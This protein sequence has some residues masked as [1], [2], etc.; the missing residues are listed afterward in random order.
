MSS[1]G[2][3]LDFESVARALLAHARTLLVE[4]F[5]A[6]RL[7][8]HEFLVGN[9]N[10]EPGESLSINVETGEWADFAEPDCRGGDLI[11]LYAAAHHIS[12]GEAA[13][14]LDGRDHT[15]T[16]V[17][18]Q[19]PKRT[20]ILP[21]PSTHDCV[22]FTYGRPSQTW[23]YRDANSNLLGYVARYDT[24]KGKQIAPWTYGHRPGQPPDWGM[25]SWPAPR[26]LYGLDDPHLKTSTLTI[27]VEGEKCVDSGRQIAPNCAVL[28][29]PGGAQAWNRADW[30]PLYGRKVIL[31]PDADKA[32]IQAMYA[33]GHELAKHCPPEFIKIIL[34]EPDKPQGWDAANALAEKWNFSTLEAWAKQ[35]GEWI[36]GAPPPAVTS[37]AQNPVSSNGNRPSA[38]RTIPDHFWI[39]WDLDRK[40][41]GYPR[42]NANNALTVIENATG[43][44]EL[45][46]DE[47]LS[48]ILTP[49]HRAG[50]TNG[51]IR[52]WTDVDNIEL[53]I[54]MQR[55]LGLSEMG[56]ESVVT[57]VDVYAHQHARHCVRTYLDALEW[58]GEPRIEHFFEDHFG[59]DA[60]AYT[61][62]VSKNFWLS[63]AARIYQPGCKVDNMIVLEGAQGIGK[64]RALQ[65][66]GGDW[67]TEQHENVS[68]HKAFAEVLQGKLIIEIS[69][70]DSFSR[71]DITKVKAA[72]TDPIDRYRDP[73]DRY[74]KDH[75]RQCVFVGTTNVDDWN[76]DATGARRFW[77]I[78]CTGEIDQAAIA[79]GRDQFFAEAVHLYRQGVSWW[80][81]PEDETREAQAKR[82]AAD[83]W[84]DCFEPHLA[85]R[86]EVTVKELLTECLN[87][88]VGRI[89]NGDQQ[90][91]AQ[92]LK[93]M[94]WRRA[95]RGPSSRRV[96]VWRRDRVE[97]G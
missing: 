27:L 20:V 35:R 85:D 83:V 50:K 13:R 55:N 39:S 19:K 66:I 63:I 95:Q 51:A 58:D 46:Y 15:E 59:A 31:W 82:Y 5:P 28:T 88:E 61:R 89:S 41:N 62:A 87:I 48:R 70:M 86:E 11:S 79:A 26:P 1:T 44:C 9:L 84:Q 77:P 24:D 7:R 34:P 40:G 21:A 72:I 54:R 43:L 53:L 68:D 25:G 29:W 67:F 92:I 78:R 37:A 52:E 57:A 93:H 8:G 6:G 80:L 17:V 64:S 22:H 49:D 90:R 18:V 69:E 14:E 32:G 75:P 10:G 23:A 81:M 12:N 94:G 60:T 65:I 30:K 47:F 38:R 45:W 96:R 73:Y 16:T 71:A 2:R 74:S 3:R 97:E 76:R 36:N 56:K 42:S 33:I 4:W 91:V